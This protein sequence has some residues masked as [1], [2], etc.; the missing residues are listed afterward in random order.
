MEINIR[1]KR[2]MKFL[3]GILLFIGYTTSPGYASHEEDSPYVGS[4]ECGACHLKEYK[5]W[6]QTNLSKALLVLGPRKMMKI[7]KNA[8]LDPYEDYTREPKC[9]KC[10][11]TGFELKKDGSYVFA[12]YGIGCEACHGAGK[13]YSKIMRLRGR[14]YKR[15]ELIEAGLYAD[16]NGICEKCHNVESPVID[17]DY[18]FSHKEQ[19]EKVHIPVKLKYHQQIE[20]FQN[21]D[22]KE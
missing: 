22:E 3:I 18:N 16:F 9:L 14:D 6:E 5:S 2:A 1:Q 12:E 17:A 7:K 21:E 19:Y 15:E 10:H 13:K 11:T 8:G 4:E 20:R